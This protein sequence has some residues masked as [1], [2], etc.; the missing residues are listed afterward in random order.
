MGTFPDD[1]WAG[2]R[3]PGFPIP[4]GGGGPRSVS[5][6]IPTAPGGLPGGGMTLE[7]LMARQKELAGRSVPMTDMTSPLQGVAYAL[8]QGLQGFREGGAAKDVATGQSAVASALS[9]M[10]EHGELTP[11]GKAA[12]AQ[13]DPQTFLALWKNQQ[14]QFGPVITGDAA[15]ALG[16][17]PTKSYQQN[18][19]TG[20]YDPIGGGTTFDLGQKTESTWE[21]KQAEAFGKQVTAADDEGRSAQ[22]RLADVGQL[23]LLLKEGVPTGTKAQLLTYLKDNWGVSLGDA[24]DKVSAFNSLIDRIAPTMRPTGSGPMSDSDVRMFKNGLPSLTT[25]PEGNALIIA[26]MKGVAEYNIAVGNL[27]REVSGMP[28]A[29]ARAA[30]KK[31]LA[32]LAKSMDP[33]KHVREYLAKSKDTAPAPDDGSGGPAKPHKPRFS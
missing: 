15:K 28:L 30:W 18:L 3:K 11:E 22:T 21:G 8:Q 29:E 7:A 14:K 25:S 10:G 12:L 17:D 31:G 9:S 24:S 23:E 5:T 27:A 1:P 4:P 33:L 20:Q 26:G 16:L 2:M 19:S 6:T 13:Y 32:D